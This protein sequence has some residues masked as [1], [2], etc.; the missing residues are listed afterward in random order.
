[1]V[2]PYP[3]IIYYVCTCVL[4]ERATCMVVMNDN[5]E[6]LTHTHIRAPH[7]PSPFANRKL[8]CEKIV[9]DEIVFSHIL[10]CLWIKKTIY[11]T[12]IVCLGS[13][14]TLRLSTSL[15]VCLSL[16]SIGAWRKFTRYFVLQFNGDDDVLA[17][18]HNILCVYGRK[19]RKNDAHTKREE[20]KKNIDERTRRRKRSKPND[21]CVLVSEWASVC[22]FYAYFIH[23]L[24]GFRL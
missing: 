4:C 22:V 17:Y 20:R 5:D 8:Q 6:Y 15:S 23:N 1:M 16:F 2:I 11:W 10:F 19:S 24:K 3:K 9:E 14:L 7:N 18:K 13:H 12:D 21:L